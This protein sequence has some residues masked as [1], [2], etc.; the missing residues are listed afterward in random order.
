MLS[1]LYQC[2]VS[3]VDC[4]RRHLRII[5]NSVP[6]HTKHH[7][8]H[9]AQN[10][11]EFMRI[12]FPKMNSARVIELSKHVA[13]LAGCSDDNFLP[14]LRIIGLAASGLF[15]TKSLQR[16]VIKCREGEN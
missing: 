14:T 3:R 9:S 12:R 4:H 16:R 10:D 15:C 1:V 11:Y 13:L 6:L 2:R 5:W 8:R 7:A